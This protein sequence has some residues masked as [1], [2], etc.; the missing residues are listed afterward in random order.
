VVSTNVST[1]GNT[2]ATFTIPTTAILGTTRMRVSSKY[3]AYS[4]PCETFTYGEVEDYTINITSSTPVNVVASSRE[5]QSELTE[6]NEAE[7]VAFPNP[8]SD[9]VTIR[10]NY[11]SE[12]NKKM[13]KMISSNGTEVGTQEVELFNN[14]FRIDTKKLNTGIYF[15]SVQE[16]DKQRVVKI[17]KQ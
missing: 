4:T 11:L 12:S 17:I 8:V 7:I 2:S 14:E 10:L 5:I 6:S 1:A 15:I 16:P 3:G 9:I 13:V